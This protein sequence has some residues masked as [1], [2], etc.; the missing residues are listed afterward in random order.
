M[1][2]V[3]AE[4][5]KLRRKGVLDEHGILRLTELLTEMQEGIERDFGG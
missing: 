3:R 2:L 5:D 4:G 1:E